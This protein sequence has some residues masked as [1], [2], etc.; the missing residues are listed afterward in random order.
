MTK[1][2]EKVGPMSRLPEDEA[3]WEALTGR[4]VMVAA[5]RLRA[6][7][8]DRRRW[9]HG[10]SRLSAPLTLAAAASVVAAL[11]WLP[12]VRGEGPEGA[13]ATTVFGLAPASPLADRLLDSPTA[14]T[15]ATLFVTPTSEVSR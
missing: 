3:Y 6:Y 10:L 14:P 4:L 15:M 8:R 12:E 13:R 2:R 9:W 1:H 11:L 7:R 5:G